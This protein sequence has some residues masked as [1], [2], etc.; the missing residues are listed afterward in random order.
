MGAEHDALSQRKAETERSVVAWRTHENGDRDTSKSE[1]D[2]CLGDERIRPVGPSGWTVPDDVAGGAGAHE[3][4][5]GPR[6][7]EGRD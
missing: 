2:Q 4:R 5:L 1:L 6:L 3:T 7:C